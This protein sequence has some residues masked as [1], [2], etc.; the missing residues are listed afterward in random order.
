MH[1]PNYRK[2][3]NQFHIEM[4]LVPLLMP[5]LS[6]MLLVYNFVGDQLLREIVSSL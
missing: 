6:A 2:S 1:E 4:V 5:Y 3:I